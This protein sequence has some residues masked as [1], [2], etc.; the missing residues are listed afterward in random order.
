MLSDNT[1]TNISNAKSSVDQYC[2]FSG[3]ISD[4]C[5]ITSISNVT[6]IVLLLSMQEN[7]NLMTYDA[8]LS[9]AEHSKQKLSFFFKW[10]SK[11]TLENVCE[12]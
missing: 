6:N 4:E 7:I 3:C 11:N 2:Y 1:T 10:N 5:N 8:E 12:N 9:D